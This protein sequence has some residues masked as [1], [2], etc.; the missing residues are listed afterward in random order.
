MYEHKDDDESECA[1]PNINTPKSD[2]C[3]RESQ[4]VQQQQQKQ[5]QQQRREEKKDEEGF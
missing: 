5:K 3:K 2:A 1:T 4:R